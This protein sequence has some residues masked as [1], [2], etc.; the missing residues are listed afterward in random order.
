MK[1]TVWQ[2]TLILVF[3]AAAFLAEANSAL[4]DVVVE[5]SWVTVA[6]L[7]KP[8]SYGI[9]GAAA[10]DGKI[11][12]I[13]ENICARYD[14]ETDKWTEI[15]QPPV[16]Y[17][18]SAVA[19]CQ[20]KIY[21]I[22]DLTQV[23]DPATDTWEN[24]TA[25]PITIYG[26]QANVVNDKIYVISGGKPAG[27][28][29]TDPSEATYVYDPTTDSWSTMAPIPTPVDGYAS[30][31]LDNKI[32][33]IGGGTA[34]GMMENATNIVQ[35][36]NP[37]TNKWTNGTSMPT[38]VY[39]AGACSTS[40]IFAPKRIYVVGGNLYYNTGGILAPT[41]PGS[42]LNQ[43]YDPNTGNWSSAAALPESRWL[44]P[45]VNVNDTLYAVGGRNASF[46]TTYVDTQTTWKY[47]PTG[48]NPSPSPTPSATD[49]F[50]TNLFP[51]IVIALAVI[52]AVT[53]A[54]VAVHHKRPKKNN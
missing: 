49:D 52:V 11:Y 42:D 33:I 44:V 32:Y 1:K 4:G 20:N 51:I 31:I 43:V 2:Q 39:K 17:A 12:F 53:I 46:V 21:V 22:G 48:Y 29:I 23:Y 40:G 7:P 38:G 45:L 35:I 14:I 3:L 16:Y 26:Y 9:L 24:R 30:A 8:Y 25:L 54:G 50:T 15:T 37:Q 34:T 28:S 13:G 41:F 10:L 19:A 6:P 47:T 5:D 18:W 27:L 36:F